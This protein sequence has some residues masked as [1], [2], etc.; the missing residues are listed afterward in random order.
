MPHHRYIGWDFALTD[1]GWVLIEGNWG[2]FLS[3]Y[4]DKI[5]LKSK[6]MD[7]M[8]GCSLNE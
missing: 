3:Q 4:V 7:C 6:F 5:G 8:Y 2:Q 1:D